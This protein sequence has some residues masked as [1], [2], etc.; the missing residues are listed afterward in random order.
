[1][2][3]GQLVIIL[4]LYVFDR[5][6]NF[7]LFFNCENIVFFLILIKLIKLMKVM[8]VIK[9]ITDGINKIRKNGTLL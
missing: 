5:I 3:N 1:M 9:V 4:F 8:K 7:D 6:L 2:V